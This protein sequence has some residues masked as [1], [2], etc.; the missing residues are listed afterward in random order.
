[1]PQSPASENRA[2]LAFVMPWFGEDTRGGA[3]LQGWETARALAER[4]YRVEVL[5]TC[6]RSFL[7]RWDENYYRAGESEREGVP[8]RRFPV[9]PRDESLFGA[10][11]EALL[12]GATLTGEQEDRFVRHNINSSALYRFIGENAGEY[13]FVFLPYLYGT[14]LAGA[15]VAP[16]RSLLMP[17]FHDE[18]YAY[19]KV[20]RKLFRSVRGMLYLT[21]EEAEAVE[22]VMG[23]PLPGKVTG[24]GIGMDMTGSAERFRRETGIEDPIIL[25]VG[26]LDKGKNTHLL[27]S[28][29]RHWAR[30][31]GRKEKLVLIGGGG[32]HLPV[33][34]PSIIH[35]DVRDDQQKMDA[36]AAAL[37]LCQPS[38]NESFSR[39]IMEAWLNETP[40]VVSARCPVTREHC[41]RSGGGLYFEDYF[42]FE[43]IFERLSAD[44]VLRNNLGK[45]G[46]RYVLD[47]YHWDIVT[48]RLVEAV[49]DLAGCVPARRGEG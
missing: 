36:C 44:G 3:E 30:N 31:R 39:V 45:A 10:A 47:N 2:A 40:V 37:A 38:V 11:N 22:K 12:S 41:R 19:M 1:M 9:D 32:L 46:R 25:Y 13:V 8:V 34:D 7:H 29:F 4:D 20:T 14:T 26:R 42:E 18:A 23:G 6:S 27:V 43:E 24:G 16:K 33:D 15:A 17:C 28:Y 21:P 35:L 49:S 48:K 5:T